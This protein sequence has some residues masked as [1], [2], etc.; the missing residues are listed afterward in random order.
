MN[1]LFSLCMYIECHITGCVTFFPPNEKCPV[2]RA[3]SRSAELLGLVLLYCFLF[4]TPTVKTVE[5][6]MCVGYCGEVD[7]EYVLP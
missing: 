5:M 4:G 2:A 1:L 7:D 6:S 3:L